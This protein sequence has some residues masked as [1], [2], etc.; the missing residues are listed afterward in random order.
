MSVLVDLNVP[1][2]SVQPS[3]PDFARP[4]IVQR[5]LDVDWALM[6][7]WFMAKG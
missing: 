5:E 4:E 1:L 3:Q 7:V 2:R 6:R